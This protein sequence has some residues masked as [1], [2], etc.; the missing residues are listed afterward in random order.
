MSLPRNPADA[1][2]RNVRASVKRDDALLARIEKLE[3]TLK[4]VVAALRAS[5]HVKFEHRDSED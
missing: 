5:Q 4:V 3:D 1:T 2:T